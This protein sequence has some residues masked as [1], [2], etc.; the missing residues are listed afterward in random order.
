MFTRS[1]RALLGLWLL[2]SACAAVPQAASADPPPITG[3]VNVSALVCPVVPVIT[4]PASGTSSSSAVTTIKG[5]AQPGAVVTVMRNG[6]GAGS[7]PTDGAGDWQLDITLFTGSNTVQ[8]VTCANSNAVIITYN[9]PVPPPGP[10]P[11][12]PQPPAP[13]PPAQPSTPGAPG[14]PATPGSPAQ[15]PPGSVP[16]NL[17]ATSESTVISVIAG[18]LA[19]LSIIIN[20]GQEP[21]S[22]VIEWGDGS[23][24]VLKGNERILSVP[25]RYVRAGTFRAIAR[26]TDQSGQSASISYVVQVEDASQEAGTRE[27]P[28]PPVAVGLP[29]LVL[30]LLAFIVLTLAVWEYFHHRHAREAA[31]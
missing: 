31:R 4:F 10:Q 20:N 5:T 28:R 1:A 9:P 2:V 26:I 17:F 13:Q 21:F 27:E 11:P 12:A 22:V 30:L 15:P 25:H 6:V 16:G 29:W 19:H 18:E 7:T 3:T 14:Q 24:T 8:A 23:Q